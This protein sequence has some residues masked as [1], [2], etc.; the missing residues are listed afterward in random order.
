MIEMHANLSEVKSQAQYQ[1]KVGTFTLQHWGERCKAMISSPK[2]LN[3]VN[4]IEKMQHLAL[5]IWQ[6]F[7]EKL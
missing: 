3:S 7:K 1:G 2:L 6:S 4:R 5:E